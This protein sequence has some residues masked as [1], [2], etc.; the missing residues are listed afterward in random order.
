MSKRITLDLSGVED[1]TKSSGDFP[2]LPAGWYE[3]ALYSVEEKSTGPNSKKPGSPYYNVRLN[4]VAG[5]SDGRVVFDGFVGLY[6]GVSWKIEQLARA[7]DLWD[8]EDRSAFGV[9]TESELEGNIV[10]ANIK[11]ERDKYRED[12]RAKSGDTSDE[13]IFRNS[14]QAYRPVGGWPDAEEVAKGGSKKKKGGAGVT[15]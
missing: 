10:E 11:L 2:P 3:V 4:I 15:L 7:L 12:E 14:V 5:E 6:E 1:A 8:G 9:P 13:P